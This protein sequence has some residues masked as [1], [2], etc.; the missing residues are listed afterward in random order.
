MQI[1]N[2]SKYKVSYRVKPDSPI[3][4]FKWPFKCNRGKINCFRINTKR[5]KLFLLGRTA[6]FP[7]PWTGWAK[8]TID[9]KCSDGTVVLKEYRKLPEECTFKKRM[10]YIPVRA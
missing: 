8:V 4:D 10:K 3:K 2:V 6:E 1:V 7:S 9:T 5:T